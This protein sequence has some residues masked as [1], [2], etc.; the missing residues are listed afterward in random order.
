M[1]SPSASESLHLAR[2]A[3]KHWAATPLSE[4][5][6]F[7]ARLRKQVAADRELLVEAIMADTGKPALD[8]LGGD[9]LVT[10]EQMRLYERRAARLLAPRRVRRSSVFFKG[11]R[12]SEHFEPYGTALIFGPANYPLQ[13]SLI[14]AVTALYAG[15]AAVLKVSERTPL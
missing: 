11:C 3:Q 14:P 4:R 13:L 10:L 1:R 15:N 12:F 2:E 5:V 9:V 6:R 7:L 8:A